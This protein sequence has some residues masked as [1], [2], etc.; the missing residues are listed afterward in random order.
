MAA[1]TAIAKRFYL[2]AASC[3][4]PAL[5]CCSFPLSSCCQVLLCEEHAAQIEQQQPKWQQQQ[6]QQRDKEKQ[7]QQAAAKKQPLVSLLTLQ[8]KKG[9][10]GNKKQ[11]TWLTSLLKLETHGAIYAAS[12]A[13][14]GAAPDADAD[15]GWAGAMSVWSEE[16]VQGVQGVQPNGL[17]YTWK[18]RS[19]TDFVA[20]CAGI[21]QDATEIFSEQQLWNLGL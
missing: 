11:L 7:Q 21:S 10:K 12:S 4:C 5:P 13:G 19:C 16:R 6:Q 9:S 15:A 8:R 17:L 18:L 20:N 14:V 3:P 2:P 1:R